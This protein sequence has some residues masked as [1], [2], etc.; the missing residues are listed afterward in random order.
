MIPTSGKVSESGSDEQNG[1]N[2]TKFYSFDEKHVTTMERELD[3]TKSPEGQDGSKTV[4]VPISSKN[5]N[6]KE[7]LAQQR[8]NNLTIHHK[9]KS[10]L[11][12]DS[13]YH[14]F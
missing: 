7:Y 11:E 5:I 3:C 1:P 9:V 6:V 4:S 14:A 2:R 12:K 13:D 8:K 10:A